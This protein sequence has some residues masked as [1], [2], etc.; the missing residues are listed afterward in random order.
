M[1]SRSGDGG[2]G[3]AGRWWRRGAPGLRQDEPE[4]ERARRRGGE[5]EQ[6]QAGERA[7][8]L[9]EGQGAAW[10]REEVGGGGASGAVLS[11]PRVE[12]GRGAEGRAAGRGAAGL[13]GIAGWIGFFYF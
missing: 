4:A 11:L 8:G 12:S 6:A 3:C 10:G 2:S 13:S 7:A 5:P 1:R 9:G